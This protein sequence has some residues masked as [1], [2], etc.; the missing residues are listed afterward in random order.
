MSDNTT[1]TPP[2]QELGID[3]EL[4]PRQRK[5]YETIKEQNERRLYDNQR[6]HAERVRTINE[7]YQRRLFEF[8]T[9][10]LNDHAENERRQS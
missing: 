3:F 7:E 6:D 2:E 4:T 8:K 9:D 1:I 10:V 5:Q